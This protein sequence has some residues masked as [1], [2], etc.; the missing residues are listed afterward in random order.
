MVMLLTTW[1]WLTTS[2]AIELLVGH[3][4]LMNEPVDHVVVA[5]GSGGTL[6][7]LALAKQL[8]GATWQLPL[9][10]GKSTVSAWSSLR[11]I[12]SGSLA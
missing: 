2:I 3:L 7:G 4:R 6:A 10:A 9:G 5:A 11:H 12:G 8:T 1:G